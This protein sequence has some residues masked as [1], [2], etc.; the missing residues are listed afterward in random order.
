MNADGF[1]DRPFTLEKF[2]DEYRVAVLGDS[3]VF[4]MIP[5]EYGFCVLLEDRAP[6]FRFMN[7]GVIG[8]SPEDYLA[9]LEKDAMRFSPDAV[10]VFLY[11][12]NDFM[13]ARRSWYERSALITFVYRLTKVARTYQGQD[14]RQN[15]RYDDDMMPFTR[16]VY[17]QTQTRYAR[18]YVDTE[19][20]FRGQFNLVLSSL[21]A[22]HAICRRA[23][24]AFRVVLLPDRQQFDADIQGEVARRLSRDPNT[25]DWLRPQRLLEQ[26][27]YERQISYLDLLP[28]FTASA[29]RLYINHDIH[30]NIAGNRL[31]RD[32]IPDVW[33]QRDR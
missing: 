28:A 30:L 22:M 33:L 2:P 3:F 19:Q 4:G 23:G 13:F 24:V 9:V 18:T 16:E 10:W 14:I 32:T 20:S 7:F 26:A 27:L 12:G 6:S 31:V 11:A 25:V 1:K 21:D 17:M 8:A 29:Q 5:Y 15:Y